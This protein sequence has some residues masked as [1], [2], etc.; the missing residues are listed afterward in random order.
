MQPDSPY[1]RLALAL[2]ATIGLL[3]L[4]QLTLRLLFP[5]KTLKADLEQGNVA[6]ALL[7]GGDL[8]GIFLIAANIT[9]GSMEERSVKADA[10]WVSSFSVAALALFFVSSRMGVRAL[11]KSRLNAEI[12]AGNMA[13]GVAGGAH[14]LATGIIVAKAVSGSSRATTTRRRSCRGTWLRR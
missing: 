1:Y 12:E 5:K 6:R 2:A 14:S 13:A 11:L 4:F 8:F 7:H 3:L 10:I 9:M